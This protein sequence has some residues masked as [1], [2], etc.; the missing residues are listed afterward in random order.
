MSV[1]RSYC[2]SFFFLIY[3]Y[4]YIYIYALPLSPSSMAKPLASLPF[5]NRYAKVSSPFLQLAM[6]PFSESSKKPEEQHEQ[7][8]P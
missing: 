5:F 1:D 4:I 3:I 7:V 6:C 8:P 2:V